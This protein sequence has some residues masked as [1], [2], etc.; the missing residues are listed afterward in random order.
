MAPTMRYNICKKITANFMTSFA[1]PDRDGYPSS[2]NRIPITNT[3]RHSTISFR[4]FWRSSLVVNDCSWLCEDYRIQHQE[5]PEEET[6]GG[7][8]EK[9]IWPIHSGCVLIVRGSFFSLCHNP[10][11]PIEWIDGQTA[12]PDFCQHGRYK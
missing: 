8:P 1:A 6:N 3:M 11:M 7:R 9:G 5:G 2:M 10:E 4:R 12:Y